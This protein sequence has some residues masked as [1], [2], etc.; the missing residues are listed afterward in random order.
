MHFS[1]LHIHS[2]FSDGILSP[3]DIIKKACDNGVQC[4]SITDHD[5]IQ[6]QKVLN[7]S[8]EQN[9][10]TIIPGL[11]LSTE[12][13]CYEIHVLGYFVDIY[14]ENL[15]NTLSFIHEC[16]VNRI[17][18]IIQALNK[19]GLEIDPSD[20][21]M[22]K[23]I[24]IGRPHIAKILVDKGYSSNMKDAFNVYLS[25]GKPGYIERY[26]INYKDAI[27][28]ICKSGGVPVLAHPGEVY[29]GLDIEKLVKEFKVYGLKGLEVF[30]PSHSEFECNKFYNLAK[31]YSFVITGGSDYHGFNYKSDINIGSFGL[32]EDLTKKFLKYKK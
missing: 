17:N 27:R 11:E 28:L 5:T 7:E 32:S 12:F 22:D 19:I 15:Q 14:D 23:C 25:K 26:K 10:I 8:N 1:D 2:A 30:H 18:N 4:I 13:N 24:S 3:Q 16:R 20:L 31:K 21:E 6:A 9:D 29:K